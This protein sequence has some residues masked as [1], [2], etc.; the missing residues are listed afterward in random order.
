MRPLQSKTARYARMQWVMAFCM[1]VGF[2]A[3]YFVG[4]RPMDKK[5]RGLREQIEIKRQE[6]AFSQIKGFD[7]DRLTRD[8]EHLQADVER[9]GKR[10]PKEPELGQFIADLYQVGQQSALLNFTVEPNA[11]RRF[12][13]FY[14]LPIKMKFEGDFSN[15]ARFLRQVEDLQRLTRV[16]HLNVKS[17]PDK[18]GKEGRVDVEVVMNI[19]F[20]D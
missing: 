4:Y 1:L 17:R 14:E 10:L 2:A 7:L 18:D 3:F 5:L 8:V 6:L 19:Y 16:N 11:S 9:N 15:A 13:L 20:G 12:D